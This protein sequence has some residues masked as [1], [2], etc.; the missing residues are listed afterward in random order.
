VDSVCSGAEA[1]EAAETGGYGAILMDCL[2]P[3]MDGYEATRRIRELDG[4]TRHTLIIALTA[5]A[6]SGDRERCLAAGMDDYVSKPIDLQTLT[7][8]L[9]RNQ[10]AAAD[11]LPPSDKQS[12]K[13]QSDKPQ[14]DKPQTDRQHEA[15]RRRDVSTL[16]PSLGERGVETTLLARLDLIDSRLPADAFGRICQEFLSATPE[17]I[18]QL[19]AAVRGADRA[20]AVD[21]AH[22]LKGG[23]VTIGALRLSCL[24]ERVEAGDG[25]CDEIVDEMDVEYRRARD[26]VASLMPHGASA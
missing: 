2:M 1:I 24:A 8:A 25:N 7:A 18:A 16:S 23:M 13:P 5:A 9:A 10:T 20:R 21:L 4:P 15:P 26:V 19:G 17:L 12:D 3:V 11:T 6:M 14:S 22:R